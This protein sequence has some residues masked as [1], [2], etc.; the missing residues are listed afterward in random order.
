MLTV[1]SVL[2]GTLLLS[3][4]A[5]ADFDFTRRTVTP[6]NTCGGTNKYTCDPKNSYGGSCCSSSGYCGYT[7]AYCG[8][9]CQSAYGSCFGKSKP[10]VKNGCVWTVA[11]VGSF[12]QF[13]NITF[14]GTTLPSTL[15]ADGY[16]IDANYGYSKSLVSVA[17]GYLQLKVPGGQTTKPYQC[18]QVDTTVSD[19]L[20]ASVRTTAI[21]AT[22][23]GTVNGNFFYWNDTQEIDIEYVTDPN[24]QSNLDNKQSTGSAKPLMYTNQLHTFAPRA[25]PSD[26]QTNAHEY[27]IDWVKG[28]T[29]FYLDGVLQNT[30]FTTDVP[31]HAGSWIWN[32]WSYV[33]DCSLPYMMTKCACANFETATATRDSRRDHLL[34]TASSRSATS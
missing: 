7:N 10:A 20:Y 21:F 8:S 11:G 15:Q 19:I 14:P 33:T 1:S 26:A 27:R 18:A 4:V 31:T 2:F 9:G 25:S 22:P 5:W 3:P 23:A 6:D 32:N 29:T 12:T 34:R 16:P 17:G 24:S 28:K 30:T 13:Q